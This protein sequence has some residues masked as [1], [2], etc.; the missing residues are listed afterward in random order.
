MNLLT[1]RAPV[2]NWMRSCDATLKIYIPG[3]GGSIDVVHMKWSAC[4]AGDSNR[5]KGKEGYPTVAFEVITDFDRRIL[6]ISSIQF[7]TRNDKHI[8]KLDKAVAEIRDGWYSTVKWNF[9]DSRGRD[10]TAVGVYL[11]C[12][13]GYL[14]WPILIC[15]YAS[16]GVAT[17]EGYFSSN[18]E[19]VRKDV[20]CVFGIL[21]K[22]WRIVE[23][24]LRFRDIKVVEKYLWCLLCFTTSCS[25]RWSHMLVVTVLV[26]VV[27]SAM[28]GFGSR[29]RLRLLPKRVH[30][31]SK[32]L[33]GSG[34][35][36][37]GI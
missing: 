37:G 10:K 1:Y 11:I 5:A 33:R 17:L 32:P 2:Q 29:G 28:T 18:L 4:P 13:G 6:A 35:S 30:A 22:R 7:G 26:A 16:A 25:P 14:R 12:D 27:L 24:G 15:P 34:Q 9:K 19:S 8:V 23:A 21:K 20:E 31:V 3:A 36:V